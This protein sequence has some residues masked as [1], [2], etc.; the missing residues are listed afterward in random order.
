MEED[1]KMKNQGDPLGTALTDGRLGAIGDP[2]EELPGP[3]YRTKPRRSLRSRPAG[4][5]L[6][7]IAGYFDLAR[8]L[9][10]N[11]EITK[12]LISPPNCGAYI[13]VPKPGNCKQPDIVDAYLQLGLYRRTNS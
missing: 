11:T 4:T 1:F 8:I 5:K 6:T 2:T 10:N 13:L 3:N 12:N 7:L 9:L